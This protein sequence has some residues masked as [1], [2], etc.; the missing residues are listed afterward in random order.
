VLSG[1]E[2]LFG[3]VFADLA[4]CLVGVSIYVAV[5]KVE[6]GIIPIMTHPDNCNVLD[7]VFRIW[8]HGND[9]SAGW[10][11]IVGVESYLF[12]T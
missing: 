1:F 7:M 4:A 5:Q 10:P 9:S 12:F 2:Q 6:M 11:L 3:D 8:G